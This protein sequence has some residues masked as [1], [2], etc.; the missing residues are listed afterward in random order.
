MAIRYIRRPCVCCGSEH[1]EPL[2]E[3][4]GIR[5]VVDEDPATLTLNTQICRD[6]GM[7]FIN[8]VPDPEFYAG[9]YRSYQR[10]AA[11]LEG[12]GRGR[13]RQ[14]Q[15]DYCVRSLAG[16]APGRVFDI[17]AH[18]GSLLKLFREDGWQ[19][20]GCDLS[21]SGREFARRHHGIALEQVSF[22]DIERPAG[23][24]DVITIFQV[25]EHIIEPLPLL[26]KARAM[27]RD[28]GLF[29]IEVPNLD[30]PSRHNL[31]N[32]FDFEHVSYFQRQSLGNALAAAG[33]VVSSSEI[34]ARNQALRV[35]AR[36]SD[37][38]PALV[39]CYAENRRRVLDY[40][41]TYTG[42]IGQVEARLRPHLSGPVILYGAGQ[43]TEQLLREVP[44]AREMNVLGLVDS[45]PEKWGKEVLGYPVH[46]PRW[47][48]E[49]SAVPVVISS[50]TFAEAIA[51]TI[52][53]HN[54]SLP[55]IEL[56]GHE[57]D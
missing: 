39:S 43:H 57:E 46:P 16:A 42:I 14:Q 28:D 47:L 51:R 22:L 24:F 52:A 15:Y 41:A 50:F 4:E 31:A 44:V 48:A 21:L 7:V 56:Y 40:R 38:P 25:L 17:G 20:E 53:D 33:F 18:D 5:V 45:S 19:V 2:Y 8:P 35:V 49:Q 27:L 29:I 54:P 55:I 34:Y 3:I 12:A 30:R 36:K 32:Y 6:C 1:T 37:H 9:Y 23:C 10:V 11:S 26:K 13:K